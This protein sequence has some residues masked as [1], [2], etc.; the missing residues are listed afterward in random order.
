MLLRHK[1][2]QGE[3][4][5]W[6]IILSPIQSEIDKKKVAQKLT[7]IF[8]L[9]TE[10]A[11]D[12]VANTPIIL[13]DNLTQ[14]IA[15]KLKDY[16]RTVGAETVLTN[17]VFQKRKCFRTVWP[18]PPSL[19][20]LHDWNPRH[21]E[22]HEELH[23]DEAL[24]ELR[25]LARDEKNPPKPSLAS[26]S[27]FSRS[28][29]EA[30][31]DEAERWGKENASL[32][33]EIKRLKDQLDRE[34]KE[35]LLGLEQEEEDWSEEKENEIKETKTLLDHANEKYDILRE[36]YANAQHLYEEKIAALLQEAEHVKRKLH[37]L[38]ESFKNQQ[39][40]RQSFEDR[41]FQ[42]DHEIQAANEEN[43]KLRLTYEQKMARNTEE[44]SRVQLQN[45]DMAEKIDILQKAK[46]ELETTVNTQAEQITYWHE[47]HDAVL[48]KVILLEKKLEEEK[49]FRE[50]IEGRQKDFEKSHI[51]LI[52]DVEEKAK[53]VRD[54]ELK[55]LELDKQFAELKEAY[56]NQEKVLQN[57]FRHLETRE[58]ELEMARR[59]LRE[60]N[61][62]IE[63]RE[64]AQK[65]NIL[66]TQLVEKEAF[67]KKLVRDQEK[68]ENEIKEREENIRAIL[69][70]QESVEKEIV[71]AKQTQRHLAEIAKRDQK[72][73]VKISRE[74]QD[75]PLGQD[76]TEHD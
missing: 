63:Q 41:I 23:P 14:Q 15:A 69:S 27:F 38:E 36:E 67:L 29:N 18:E 8:S 28:E 5:N 68:I 19:S 33:E 32:R 40:D 17:D 57:N 50:K 10:E 76:P 2:T 75:F 61:S 44:T 46:E 74:P 22:K 6:C 47:R 3:E 51:R 20:F 58:R 56:Q 9:T 35:R 34:Q 24:D 13:L 4:Q 52:Q 55:C 54:W 64:A 11:F 49:S 1:K 30:G 21:S 25:T 71:E 39:K 66:S 73:K 62:Q 60:V 42:K 45:K 48:P 16:F 43:R 31:S 26:M 65:R 53:Q 59:Q 37:E 72:G 70:Q 7:G 12:L